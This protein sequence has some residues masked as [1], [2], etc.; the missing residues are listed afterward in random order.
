M[1]YR[2]AKTAELLKQL[3]SR[4]LEEESTGTALITVTDTKVSDDFKEAIVFFTVFPDDKEKAVLDFAK[5]KRTEFKHYVK[6]ESS[7]SRIPFF[8]FQID[9]GEKNRQKIDAI[10]N[11]L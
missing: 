2:A 1:A 8:D 7:L 6:E 3:A 5:R 4:F 10:A 9:Q 11:N